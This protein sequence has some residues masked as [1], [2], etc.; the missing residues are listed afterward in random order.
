MS[1]D[2]S[3]IA[4]RRTAVAGPTGNKHGAAGHAAATCAKLHRASL[5]G[6]ITCDECKTARRASWRGAAAQCHAAAVTRNATCE[7][8][9][10]KQVA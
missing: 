2:D 6:G 5:V 7:A 1:R 10:Q 4:A 3:H 8:G 9:G